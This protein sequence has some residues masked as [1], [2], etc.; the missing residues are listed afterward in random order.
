[1]VLFTQMQNTLLNSLTFLPQED[2]CVLKLFNFNQINSCFLRPILDCRVSVL[3]LDRPLAFIGL[4][5]PY[6]LPLSL[7]YL[8]LSTPSHSHTVHMLAANIGTPFYPR[9]ANSHTVF[10]VCGSVR[11]QSLK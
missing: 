11:L 3:L 10:R 1:M 2:N 4:L 8:L 7:S 9:R 6:S 5:S